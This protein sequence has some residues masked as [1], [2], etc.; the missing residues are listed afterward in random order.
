MK[1][2]LMTAVAVSALSA[3]AASAASLSSSLS[4]IGGQ[5]LTLTTGTYEPFTIANEVD[6]PGELVAA[7]AFV[8]STTGIINGTYNVTFNVSGGTFNT[9]GSVTPIVATVVN[10]NA[11]PA[12]ATCTI[13]S[14]TTT[15]IVAQC[16]TPGSDAVAK[17]TLAAGIATGVAKAPVYISGSI[18]TT[19]GTAVDG[20][21]IASVQVVDYRTGYKTKATARNAALL[22]TTFKKMR[23]V[24]TTGSATAIGSVATVAAGAGLNNMQIASA[25]GF[26]LNTNPLSGAAAD[27]VYQA[28]GTTLSLTNIT[29]ISATVAGNL[30]VLQPVFAST[31]TSG[32]STD[33]SFTDT[34]SPATVG[35]GSVVLSANNLTAFKAGSG[36]VG[37]EQNAAI[38]AA[39]PESGY[40]LS[41]TPTLASGYTAQS[42]STK[43]IGSLSYEGTAIYA[44]WIGDG[45][46]GISTTIRLNNQGTTA[47]P[48]VQ[49]KLTSPFTTGTSGTVASTATCTLGTVPASGELLITSATLQACFG[50]FK[51]A[52]VTIVL[53]ATAATGVTAKARTTAVNG[54]V[55]EITL[56]KG[57][58]VALTF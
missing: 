6:A 36:V 13:S 22:L 3:G 16:V 28:T 18:A 37:V 19:T 1:K 4:T 27:L 41:M 55:S 9:T 29:A 2:I 43:T 10:T 39:I 26:D 31:F 44:P 40:T 38:A 21:A 8:P 24:V 7:L 5:A 51:R 14:V 34:Q 23:E 35:T 30:S 48:F 53:G 20:G 15:A 54:T 57:N 32:T 49:A 58:N 45:S 11:T 33:F 50:N 17:F 12:T 46:N 56:G 25:A 42:Y 47:I 52:D